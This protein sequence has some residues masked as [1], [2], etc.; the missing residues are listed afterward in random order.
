MAAVNATLYAVFAGRLRDT[1]DNSK[2]SRWLNRCGGSV[3]IGT[4]VF[5]VTLQRSS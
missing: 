2:V 4:G 1:I 5:T 3:L